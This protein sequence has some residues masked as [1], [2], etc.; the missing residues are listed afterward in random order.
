ML[1]CIKGMKAIS[2]TGCTVNICKAL[3]FKEILFK[4]SF[5]S[6]I[7]LVVFFLEHRLLCHR[8]G[9]HILIIFLLTI[10]VLL[11]IVAK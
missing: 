4:I 9:K 7:G 2:C 1:S 6:T 8:M 3:H 11:E 10:S 5:I